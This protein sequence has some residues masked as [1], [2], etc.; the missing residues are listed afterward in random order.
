MGTKLILEKGPEGITRGAF[1]RRIFFIAIFQR[2]LDKKATAAPAVKRT[3][4]TGIYSYDGL[5]NND[6]GFNIEHIFV[7]WTPLNWG[8]Y[9]PGNF[10]PQLKTIQN[11]GRKPLVT[12]EPWPNTGITPV[13]SNLLSDVL[14][15]KYDAIIVGLAKEAASFEESLYVRWG[16]EME[17]GAYPWAVA[18]FALYISAYR[19]FV[20]LFR[21]YASNASFIWSP[22]GNNGANNYWPGADVVHVVGLSVYELPAFDPRYWG[23]ART[24][25][26]Q[27]SEKY[28]RLSGYGK[29]IIICELGVCGAA[30]YQREY[31]TA[32]YAVFK[33]Y[34]LLLTACYFNAKDSGSWGAAFGIP[35]WHI[36]LADLK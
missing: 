7:P 29:P 31:M 19:H 17:N 35:D 2:L 34:P 28:R 11:R 10:L 26:E 30:T 36:N 25:A 32:A 27:M 13:A 4:V 3:Y 1:F 20:T 33:N 18:N 21:S 12:I 5:A 6:T 24:F 22:V 23:H 14:A 9:R 8:G 16:H 15:R